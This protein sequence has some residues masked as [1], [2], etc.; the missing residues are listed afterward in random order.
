MTEPRD[1]LTSK[2]DVAEQTA[3]E[4]IEVG[5]PHDDI[6]DERVVDEGINAAVFH[7]APCVLGRW[8][9][10]FTVEGNLNVC[11]WCERGSAGGTY[12]C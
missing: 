7:Q 9:V 6:A 10:G 12:T 1:S 4:T 5:T 2:V 3:Q 11:V 8:D